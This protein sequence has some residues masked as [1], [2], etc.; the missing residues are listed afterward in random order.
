[1]NKQ[2]KAFNIEKVLFMDCEVVRN[3][4]ELDPDSREF[5]LYQK[6]IRNR[7]TDELLT[8]QEVIEHYSKRAALRMGY[9]KI[10]SIGVGFVKGGEV[11]IKAIDQG[12]EEGIIKEFC[13]ITQSFDVICG[14]NSNYF[15]MPLLIANG[16]KYFDITEV[17]PEKFST[18]MRKPW[19][20]SKNMVDLLDIFKSTH[21]ASSSLDEVCYHFNISSPKTDLDGSKV[22]E[23]FWTNGVAKISEYVKQDVF[24]NINIFRKM[25]F[26]PI[27]E[28]FKDKNSFKIEKLP[29]LQRIFNNKNISGDDRTEVLTLLKKK[30]LPKKDKDIIM[31]II[32]ASLCTIEPHFAKIQNSK[33]VDEVIELLKQDL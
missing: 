29:L 22:S 12:T 33:E 6:K 10:V 28:S 30:K 16:M 26:E 8:E 18:I 7:E 31:D 15:D 1:M 3:N 20:L 13:N 17:L 25:R 23:E 32:R 9:N 4:K 19:E 27:F 2:L 5:E 21:Y 11:H 14:F 24:A